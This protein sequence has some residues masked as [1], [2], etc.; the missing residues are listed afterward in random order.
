MRWVVCCLLSIE[1]F[2]KVPQDFQSVFSVSK[3]PKGPPKRFLPFNIP[4]LPLAGKPRPKCMAEPTKLQLESCVEEGS[5]CSPLENRCCQGQEKIAT[6]VTGNREF[7][8]C[9]DRIISYRFWT[10]FD[11]KSGN[12]KLHGNGWIL[13]NRR[14]YKLFRQ[15]FRSG[16]KRLD[17][18]WNPKCVLLDRLQQHYN[19]KQFGGNTFPS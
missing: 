1:G 6:Q 13:S 8:C 4:Q 7:F 2:H 14:I 12:C 10:I 11:P 3:Q 19:V 18:P 9:H 17:D 15:I 5:S 16:I